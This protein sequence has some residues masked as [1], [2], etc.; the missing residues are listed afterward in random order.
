IREQWLPLF[1][2]YQFDL[3]LNG[4][5]HD[6]ERSFPCRGFDSMVGTGA[7]TGAPVQTLRPHPVTTTDSGVFD[8]R[9]GTVHLVLGGGGT[10]ANLDDYGLE[11]AAGLPQAKVFTHANRPP[12][13]PLACLHGQEQTRA[14]TR[15]GQPAATPPP[16]TASQSSTSIRAP[17]RAAKPV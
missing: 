7:A 1:D 9:H 14:R 2:K 6:Y 15:P 13:R 10:N 5:D 17:A 4:H 16:D 12:A 3:V 8:T 11:K